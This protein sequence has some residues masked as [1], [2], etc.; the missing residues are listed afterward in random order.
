VGL[1]FERDQLHKANTMWPAFLQQFRN[2]QF[3][4]ELKTNSH[5]DM[6]ADEGGNGGRLTI[7]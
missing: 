4:I 3:G 6:N 1:G 5:M 2:R 7:W